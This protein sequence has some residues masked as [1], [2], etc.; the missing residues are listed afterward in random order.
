MMKAYYQM[1]KEDV[2]RNLGASECGWTS[3]EA[4]QRLVQTGPNA[5]AEGEQKSVFKIFV[6]QFA[7][8]LVWILMIAAGISL[9]SG[10]VES[11]IVI[12]AVLILNAVLG[13]VQSVKAEKSLKALKSLSSPHAHVLRDGKKCAILSTQVVPGDVLLLEVGDMVAA[14]ARI[15]CNHSLQVNESALTGESTNVDKQD[16]EITEETPLADRVNMVYS[17]TLVTY[18]R[19]E[20]LVTATAMNTEMGKI[21]GL[22]NQT[23]SVKTPLQRSMDD[24]SRKAGGTHYGDLFVGIWNAMVSRQWTTAIAAICSGTC[25]GSNSGGVKLYCDD[26][27]GNGNAENGGAGCDY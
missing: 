14:D 2:L 24:F 21:A 12:F 8:L 23:K 26:R 22:M 3:A 25:S 4:E 18:G 9:F 19:A 7:D 5:L 6:E 10:D 13:T 16:I 15:L 20:A 27:S 1:K 11:A 17:G